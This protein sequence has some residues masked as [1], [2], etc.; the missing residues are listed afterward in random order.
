MICRL[1]KLWDTRLQRTPIWSNKSLSPLH[2]PV[3]ITNQIANFDDVACHVVLQYL[4][5]LSDCDPSCEQL[6][7]V[8]RFKYDVW[9]E[10]FACRPDGH[11]PMNQ[12]QC[13]RN[14]LDAESTV[15]YGG[16]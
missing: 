10:C 14:A 1:S 5:S 7:D 8:S 2:K 11:G 13:A 12:V 6:D 16:N 9:I 4:L 15:W 3:L